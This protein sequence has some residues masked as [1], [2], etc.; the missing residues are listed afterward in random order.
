MY[1]KAVPI[2]DGIISCAQSNLLWGAAELSYQKSASGNRH[3]QILGK[4]KGS[5]GKPERNPILLKLLF[6][7][8]KEIWP[9][10]L[11]SVPLV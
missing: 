9:P 4:L 11:R 7:R 6:I 10:F 3:M 1:Q 5:N 8:L 2:S